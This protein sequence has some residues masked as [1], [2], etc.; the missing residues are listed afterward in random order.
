MATGHA[1]DTI[2]AMSA[3]AEVTPPPDLRARGTGDAAAAARHPGFRGPGVMIGPGRTD[4]AT[5]KR[6]GGDTAAR[7]C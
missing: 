2:A 3:S 6:E 1:A 7:S 4:G 5:S